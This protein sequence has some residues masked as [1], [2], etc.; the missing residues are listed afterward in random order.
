MIGR[1]ALAGLVVVVACKGEKREAAKVVEGSGSGSGMGTVEPVFSQGSQISR[2]TVPALPFAID[3]VYEKQQPS[4]AAPYHAAGGT[5]TFFDAH[6]AK[7]PAATFTVGVPQL[8]GGDEPSFGKAILVPTTA[9]AG[10]RVVQAFA[11]AF[12]VPVP[13]P[14]PGKLAPLRVNTAVLGHG[15]GNEDNGFGGTARGTHRSGSSPSTTTT[16]SRS[17]STSASPRS[18]ASSPRKIRTT[19]RTSRSRSRCRCAMAS[20]RHARPPPIRPSRPG[21]PSS[22][23]GHGCRASV[24]RSSRTMR[25]ARS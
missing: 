9:Q 25:S 21:P 1:W 3:K 14:R 7:D 13:A 24:S 15:I 11:T 6:V 2:D 19:T 20:P 10:A 18:A 17:S 22:C 16:T 23:S 12:G 8:A 4:D 5:W